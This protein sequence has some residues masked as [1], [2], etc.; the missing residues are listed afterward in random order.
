MIFAP[1]KMP[2]LTPKYIVIITTNTHL[3]HYIGKI[4][5]MIQTWQGQCTWSNY[6]KWLLGSNLSQFKQ[7][8]FVAYILSWR[9]IWVL[10]ELVRRWTKHFTKIDQEKRKIYHIC[11]WNPHDYRIYYVN[12]DLRHQYGISVAESQTF[13]LAKRPLQRWARRNGC[14]R[15]LTFWFVFILLYLPC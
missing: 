15:R 8:I 12:I 5:Q 6:L 11:I 10:L 4:I 14:F 9:S 7:S 13:L 2:S 1:R 3:S